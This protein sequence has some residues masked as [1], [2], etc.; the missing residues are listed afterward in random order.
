M[1]EFRYSAFSPAGDQV[2]GTIE[3]PSLADALRLI[4]DK[5]ILPYETVEVAAGPA[6]SFWLSLSRSLGLAARAGLMRELATLIKADV[7]IDHALRIMVEGAGSGENGKL[8]RQL[9]EKVTA[10]QT[11]SAA[12]AAAAGSFRRDEIAMIRAGEQTGSL[13]A[14]LAQLAA[15]LERRLE[16]RHKLVSALV[17]PALLL[18]MAFISIFIIVTVLIPNIMPL[19][20]GSGMDLPVIISVLIG[21]IDFTKAFWPLILLGLAGL[22][23]LLYMLV[24]REPSRLAIDRALIG[25]PFIGAHIRKAALGAICRTVAT[26]LQSG[27]HL[28][29]AMAAAVEVVGNRIA[30]E[31]VRTARE[32]VIHGRRL[33]QALKAGRIF[34]PAS[35]RILAL[36]EE[37]NRLAE[38]LL[39]I[40]EKSEADVARST[41]RW[42]A[43]L[44]PVM[45]LVLGLMIG[46]LIMSVMQAILN[47]NEIAVR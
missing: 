45:T 17:Y 9:A 20:E 38:M 28:Q 1:A 11:L 32:Q 4:R 15:F 22:G 3:A 39:H 44:T 41:E 29:Q 25:I 37:T 2:R 26:L 16:L 40:A 34:D 27:V 13:A 7:N 19:F 43:L 21:I 5:G 18:V 12:L 23:T 36:G 14:V 33:S 31:E 8:L 47:V 42:M 46:G 24:K 30:R 35:A 10:G 6:R